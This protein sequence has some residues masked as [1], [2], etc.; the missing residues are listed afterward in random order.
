MPERNIE[1]LLTEEV[2]SDFTSSRSK[3]AKQAVEDNEFRNGKQ[4]TQKQK[5]TLRNRAQEPLVVNVI[6]PAVEQAKALLTTNKPKFQSTA[7]EDSDVRTGRVFSDLMAW[8]WDYNNGN[9]TLKQIIDDYYVKG[10]GV[11]YAYSDPN[12]DFGKGEI[13]FRSIDPLEVYLD[14]SCKDPFCQ[15]SPHIIIGKKIM[16]SQLISLYPQAEEIIKAAIETNHLSPSDNSRVELQDE[17]VSLGDVPF[18]SKGAH[19]QDR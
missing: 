8:I 15:D 7:R 17:E 9:S 18:R 3:W 2:L 11:A 5:N 10:M 13:M 16:Q 6:H 14:P 12:E 1:V 19:D 4:W